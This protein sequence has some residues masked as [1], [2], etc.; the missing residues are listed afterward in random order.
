MTSKPPDFFTW[1]E[2]QAL[3]A[4]AWPRNL[5]QA[6]EF[7]HDQGIGVI[8]SLTEFPLQR[9]LV[10]EFGMEYHHMPI[11]DF[12]APTYEQIRRF[13]G[14]VNHA[15]RLDRRVVVHCLAGRGRTGTLAACWLVSRG[16]S[17]T[18]AIE[19]V[20]RMRPGSVESACQEEAVHEFAYRQENDKD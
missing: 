4:M 12:T 20:R 13:I 18:E 3:A 14:I 1:I 5:R 7:L 9:A 2:P 8:V 11:P 15:L 16:H 19:E 6:L 10:E 17:S